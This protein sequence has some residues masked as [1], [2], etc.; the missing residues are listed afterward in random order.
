M[1]GL[2]FFY[3]LPAGAGNAVEVHYMYIIILLNYVLSYD[4]LRVNL[5]E[6]AIL[7]KL[8]CMYISKV[9]ML[10]AGAGNIIFLKISLKY[11]YILYYITI[12]KIFGTMCFLPD[13][14]MDS[15]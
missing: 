14:V 5:L 11:M 4:L 3:V 15:F 13:K 1:Y 6:L 9:R 12:A 8:N 7:L 2:T 10:S